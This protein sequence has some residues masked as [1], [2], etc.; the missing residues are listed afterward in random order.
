MAEADYTKPVTLLASGITSSTIASLEP[1]VS[2]SIE[3]NGIKRALM[4]WG[5]PGSRSIKPDVSMPTLVRQF[6]QIDILMRSMRNIGLEIDHLTMQQLDYLAL[7]GMDAQNMMVVLLDGDAWRQY[8]A[9]VESPDIVRLVQNNKVVMGIGS[10]AALMGKNIDP[11]FHTRVRVGYFG[12]RLHVDKIAKDVTPDME[13]F[14]RIPA[15]IYP[16]VQLNKPLS[17]FIAQ[18]L[19]SHMDRDDQPHL[20][21]LQGVMLDVDGTA[22][23]NNGVLFSIQHE[24]LD[25]YPII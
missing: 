25:L 16:G 4:I 10:G 15:N 17:G 23:Y 19:A 8:S 18:A 1:H 2:R 24:P 14:G 7:D 20:R 6:T 22:V 11:L 12:E 21:G 5:Y 13:A 9:L 3:A